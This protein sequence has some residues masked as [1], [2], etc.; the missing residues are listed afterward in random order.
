MLVG[1]IV[2]K[3]T[4]QDGNLISV[5]VVHRDQGGEETLSA[6]LIARID[7]DVE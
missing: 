2:N 3:R 7:E 4:D 6:D 1:Y 5:R